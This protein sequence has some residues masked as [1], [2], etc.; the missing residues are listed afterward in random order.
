MNGGMQCVMLAYTVTPRA[1]RCQRVKRIVSSVFYCLVMSNQRSVTMTYSVSSWGSDIRNAETKFF[2]MVADCL[3]QLNNGNATDLAKL[4]CITH[5]KKSGIITVIEGERLKFATPLKR[6][7]SSALENVEFKFDEKKK[8][9]V[10][11]KVGDNGGASTD[12]I[13]ALRQLGKATIASK[14]F[15][16]AFPTLAKPK[17]EKTDVQRREQ[18]HNYMA[19]FAKDNGLSIE[20]VK[21]MASAL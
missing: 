20:Q 1:T 21:A 10:K 14:A 7:L 9:G 18:L 17:A 8:S 15:K 12:R 5:G 3:E 19:K 11:I 4:L 6:I 13:Q 16:D 2:P